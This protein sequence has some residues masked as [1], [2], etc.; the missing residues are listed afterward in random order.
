M[1]LLIKL[2]EFTERKKPLEI[3]GFVAEVSGFEPPRRV[4]DLH[5]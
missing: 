1:E 4:N 2:R 3:K 5:P